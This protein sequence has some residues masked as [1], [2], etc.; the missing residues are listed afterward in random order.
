MPGE[1]HESRDCRRGSSPAT[2]AAP[3]Y[4]K[5]ENL[6]GPEPLLVSRFSRAGRAS[7]GRL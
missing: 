2:P 3:D 6:R 5:A 4:S 1:G 7:L